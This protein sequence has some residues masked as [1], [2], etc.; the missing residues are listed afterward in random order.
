M[1]KL[2]YYLYWKGDDSVSKTTEILFKV[3]AVRH[4]VAE[5]ETIFVKT[6]S[7]IK[8]MWYTPGFVSYRPVD[9]LEDFEIIDGKLAEQLYD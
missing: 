1:S 7:N 4:E 9:W 2:P 5:V 3:L 6:S 8:L